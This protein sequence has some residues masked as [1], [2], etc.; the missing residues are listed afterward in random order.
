MN[1]GMN[2]VLWN[3]NTDKL[4]KDQNKPLCPP[5]HL[6]GIARVDFQISNFKCIVLDTGIIYELFF[7]SR[8]A[9]MYH[10]WQSR[11]VYLLGMKL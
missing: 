7:T 3:V 6:T 11:K 4:S 10:S 5:N 8:E 1:V 9:I 2:P